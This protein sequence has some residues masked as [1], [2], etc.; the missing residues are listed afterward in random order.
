MTHDLTDKFAVLTDDR[1]EPLDPAA[2]VR[3]G[4]TRRRRRRRTGAALV[5]TAA[6][7]AIALTATPIAGALLTTDAPVS[8]PASS[9]R[10]PDPWMDK[11]V[12]GAKG[13]YYLYQGKIGNRPW[14]VAAVE[15]GCVVMI[16]TP[17]WSSTKEPRPIY[18]LE[19]AFVDKKRPCGKDRGLDDFAGAVGIL[20]KTKADKDTTS[21][22]AGVTSAD[23]RKVRI[24]VGKWNFTVDTIATPASNSKRFFVLTLPRQ[25]TA[26]WSFTPVR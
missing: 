1:P 18:S 6:V 21:V 7:T 11:P 17:S 10:L 4:I 25:F 14:G 22:F 16:P 15:G 2:L 8:A 9:Q 20:G 24:R 12:P 23:T 5:G 26:D 13:M 3:T 19:S